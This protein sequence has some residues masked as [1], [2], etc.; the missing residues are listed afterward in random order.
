MTPPLARAFYTLD[1]LAVSALCALSA[2]ELYG[3]CTGAQPAPVVNPIIRLALAA[4]VSISIGILF[5]R[6]N[7]NDQNPMA[8]DGGRFDSP[9]FALSFFPLTTGLTIYLTDDPFVLNTLPGFARTR[10]SIAR[11]NSRT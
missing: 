3:N 5:V 8:C 7:S 4:I 11:R 9:L 2:F 1:A 10:T 6:P